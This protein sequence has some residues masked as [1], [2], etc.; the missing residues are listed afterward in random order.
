MRQ[1]R[2]R[3]VCDHDPCAFHDSTQTAHRHADPPRDPGGALLLRGQDGLCR[4]AARR[5]QALLP[6]APAPLRK[7]PVPRHLQGAVRGQRAAVRGTRHPRPVGLVGA[8][9]RAA[10]QLRQR[11]LQGAGLPAHQP[12]G[13]TRRAGGTARRRFPLRHGRGAIRTSGPGVECAGRAA[14]RRPG[15]RVR[16]ADSGRAGRAGGRPRQPR[17]PARPL[18]GHQGQRRAHP[19]QL[20]HRCHQVLQSQP[21]LR[22]QQPQ[23]HHSA[24]ALLGHLRL[25][26]RGPG[27]RVRTGARRPGPGPGPGL[28]QRIQLAGRGQGLQPV[29]HPAAVRHARVR[30][31][32]VRDRH[33]DV[34]GGHAVRPTRELAGAGRHARQH[35]AA[36]DVRRRRHADRG[37]AVP[38]R[39]S[40]HRA[41][42]A[43]GRRDV[44][45]AGIS[46]PGGAAEP[47]PEPA[48]PDDGGRVPAG[49]AQRA[50]LRPAA[51]QRLYGPRGAVRSVLRQ[52]SVRVVHEQRHR[53]LRRLLR[54]R[55]LLVLRGAGPGR[56]GGGQQQPRPAGH[57]GALQRP[58]CTCSS[59]RWWSWRP[60]E[61]RWRS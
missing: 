61:P 2:L 11:R 14:S 9:S 60:R 48:E 13:P 12:D 35:R 4:A 26:G 6:V 15:G 45:P 41:P 32:L 36:V 38:D 17:L 53:E 43:A 30:R 50:A 10:A 19:L 33:A 54:Q 21:V 59:S 46:E 34:S 37:A 49:R 47:E 52:H 5:G 31:P 56:R 8:P 24:P 44:L 22:P 40:D 42:R 27:H 23:G 51:G 57:G 7:E 28:V 16:Q 3:Q 39:L 25:Y 29:R 20:H 58:E 55:V 18:R 1:Y